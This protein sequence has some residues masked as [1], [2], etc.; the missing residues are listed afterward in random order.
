MDDTGSRLKYYLESEGITQSEVADYLGMAKQYVN[1]ICQCRKNVSKKTAARL[2]EGFGVSAAWLLTGDGSMYVIPP[3]PAPLQEE[4]I[5]DTYGKVIKDV[6]KLN[7]QLKEEIAE[8]RRLQQELIEAISEFRK[9]AKYEQPVL[10][11]SPA[12]DEQQK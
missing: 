4:N 11:P 9:P 12:A 6:E 1:A 3:A 10:H 7:H 8:V 2:Q 5:I